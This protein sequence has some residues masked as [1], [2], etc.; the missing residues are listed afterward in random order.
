MSKCSRW[1]GFMA[2]VIAACAAVPQAVGKELKV[3]IL[4]GQSNMVGHGRLEDGRKEAG[5]DVT[6]PG[7]IGN[8]TKGIRDDLCKIQ[9]A[10]G[11]PSKHPEFAGNVASIETRGFY[12]P[13]DQS[14]KECGYHWDFNGETHFLLGEAMGKTM[15]ELIGSSSPG[16]VAAA[17]KPN[18]AVVATPVRAARTLTPEN[19]AIL[20][21]AL[22]A[23]LNKLSVSSALKEV[24]LVISP[25]RSR[26]WPK[27]AS[28]EDFTFQIVGGPQTA[29]FKWSDLRA[30]DHATLSLLVVALKPDSNDA[31]AMTAVYLESLGRVTESEKYY[32][33]AGAESRKK[34]E[35]LFE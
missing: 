31:Q 27:G 11:N 21:S 15:L 20:D 10:I 35:T 24:P 8:P 23:T 13:G 32:E 28:G 17:V 19:R 4:D 25:T 26:V 18:P 9:L 1:I 14:P 7:G 22:K 3:F 5:S 2:C 6:I 29:V 16:K 12:R 33:K 34:L 30:D